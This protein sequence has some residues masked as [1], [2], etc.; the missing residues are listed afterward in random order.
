MYTYIGDSFSHFPNQYRYIYIESWKVGKT[1]IEQGLTLSKLIGKYN[2]L[3]SGKLRCKPLWY[4][5]SRGITS[6]SNLFWKVKK[7]ADFGK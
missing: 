2:K 5:A 6:L 4:K 7:V 3:E 1:L